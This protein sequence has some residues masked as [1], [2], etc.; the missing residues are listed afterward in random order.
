MR[1]LPPR[2]PRLNGASSDDAPVTLAELSTLQARMRRL[3]AISTPPALAIGMPRAGLS[4]TAIWNNELT[5]SRLDRRQASRTVAMQQPFFCTNSARTHS[6]SRCLTRREKPGFPS[7]PGA[8]K[9]LSRITMMAIS[10]FNWTSLGLMAIVIWCNATMQPK[11]VTL[12]CRTWRSAD[13]TGLR[14]TQFCLDNR[15]RRNK[16]QARPF[17]RR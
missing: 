3:P 6:R 1:G 10:I 7:V 4:N 9:A 12:G 16:R 2:W 17:E 15:T 14:T 11:A 8:Y 13:S 5:N